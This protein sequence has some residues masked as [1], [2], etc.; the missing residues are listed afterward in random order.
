MSWALAFLFI[1]ILIVLAFWEG[2]KKGATWKSRLKGWAWLSLPVPMYLLMTGYFTTYYQHIQDCKA[3]GG[4]KVFIE[5]NKTDRIQV[6]LQNKSSGELEAKGI[7]YDSYPSLK[8]VEA[9]GNTV[10]SVVEPEQFY[11]Y[12]VLSTNNSKW[13][14]DWTFNKTPLSVP[15][16]DIYV[17]S[18]H[19]EGDSKS[20]VLKYEWRLSR[21]NTLYAKITNFSHAWKGVQYPDAVPSWSCWD[22][23]P[24]EYRQ[25]ENF[26]IKLILK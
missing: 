1:L 3:E 7:L 18:R 11:S 16:D 4:L 15:S 20:N 22:G 19:R 13:F 8:T 5:P 9:V 25:P 14:N 2:L 23:Y 10:E 17:L 24:P 12:S 21:N 6:R 26:L